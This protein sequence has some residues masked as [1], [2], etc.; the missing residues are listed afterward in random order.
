MSSFVLFLGPKYSNTFQRLHRGF[1]NND[2]EPLYVPIPTFVI[3]L[4]LS[5][6]SNVTTVD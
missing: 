5:F 4:V 6:P 2:V 1:T 3:L